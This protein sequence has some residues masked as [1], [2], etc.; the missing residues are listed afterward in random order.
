MPQPF[1]V[2]LPAA[3]RPRPVCAWLCCNDLPILL[4]EQPANGTV[5]A[6][7]QGQL[8]QLDCSAVSLVA[9]DVEPAKPQPRKLGSEGWGDP[10]RMVWSAANDQDL[11]ALAAWA[12]ANEVPIPDNGLE[13][14]QS[15]GIAVKELNREADLA[16]RLNCNRE[17]EL[18]VAAAESR[19]Q[20]RRHEN[21]RVALVRAREARQQARQEEER[22]LNE[23]IDALLQEVW[24]R[25][26]QA[27]EQ[28]L[29][30]TLS[31][32]QLAAA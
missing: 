17:A 4:I 9:P 15:Q 2:R 12:E 27:R 1:P 6:Y 14:L 5:R 31:D 22:L 3:H 13:R 21:R 11:E 26:Q 24:S 10:E 23:R 19:R 25:Q 7:V 32:R 18:N 20:S 8:K 28:R 29:Q 16:M 30:P